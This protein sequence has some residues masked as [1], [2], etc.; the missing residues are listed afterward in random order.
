MRS[1]VAFALLALALAAGAAASNPVVVARVATGTAPCGA[2]AGFGALWIANDGG[3]TVV[4]VDPARNR[5]AR[6]ARVGRTACGIAIGAGSVWTIRY[7]TGELV[8]IDP[9]SLQI[10]RLAVGHVPFDVLFAVGSV[11]V[12]AHDDGVLVRIDPRRNRVTARIPL[13]RGI[14]GLAYAGNAVWVGST[15][16]SSKI[17]RVDPRTYSVTPIDVG[18][19]APAWFGVGAGSLWAITHDGPGELGGVLRVDPANG[20]TRAYVQVGGNP[21]EA[22]LAPDGT[23]WV[24]GKAHN[25][26]TRIDP[27]TNRV[28]DVLQAGPGA[29]TVTRAF[30]DMWVTSY[31]GTD[32]WR[33]RAR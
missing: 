18:H 24:S 26:V 23:I 32:V 30:G 22:A 6:T 7:G 27:A 20:S 10:R 4:A 5:V 3:G 16:T 19:A 9:R 28:V 13:E 29:Y 1:V 17:F 31:A 2:G 15:G 11:W 33:F 25:I 21:V 12:T 14:A 8:R